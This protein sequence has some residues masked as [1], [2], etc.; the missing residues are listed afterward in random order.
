MTEAQVT[1]AQIPVNHLIDMLITIGN[2][3]YSKFLKLENAFVSQHG[4]EVWQEVFNFRI[5]PALDKP[6]SQW[7]LGQWASAGI[8]SILKVNNC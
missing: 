2:R 5:L 8:N 3:D 1:A 7:L 6:A 4:E